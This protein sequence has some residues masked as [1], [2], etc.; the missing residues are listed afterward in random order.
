MH[1]RTEHEP[2]DFHEPIPTEGLEVEGWKEIPVQ[3]NGEPLVALG[4]FS[5]GPYDRLL[6]DSLYWRERDNSPYERGA[7][8]GSLL[9]V[10]ARQGVADRLVRAEA[11]LP[12]GHHLAVWDAQRTL[13]LQ[14]SLYEAFCQELHRLHPD[15]PEARLA[16]HTQRYVSLPSTDP[17]RPS[18][19]NT[20]G[21]VDVDIF[22]LP[23]TV[24]ARVQE[25]DSR[26]REI[27]E[28]PGHASE[29]Y[30]LEM[31]RLAM[32]T[33]HAEPLGFGTLRD[34]GD[35]PAAADYFERLAGE[36]PLDGAETQARDNRRLLYNVMKAAGMQPF[37]SEWWHY[38]APESQMGARVAGRPVAGYGAVELTPGLQ[39][40]EAMRR[41]HLV[42]TVRLLQGGGK[43]RSPQLRFLHEVSK[44]T[45]DL[46]KTSLPKAEKIRPA[47]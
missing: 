17:D 46:R 36:R 4:P 16:E 44:R 32:L 11:S 8:E 25:I 39:E 13:E 21:A 18:P 45:G 38:N 42:G 19:H 28:D 35:A 40:Y 15:W 29:V 24:E 6:T 3:E 1:H 23:E 14:G 9:G 20:G 33:R 37:Q 2:V 7:L 10:Y 22:R 26:I 27:G 47:A 31:E 34:H 41:G 5:G 12:P 43:L 30:E